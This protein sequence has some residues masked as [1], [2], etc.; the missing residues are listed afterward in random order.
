MGNVQWLKRPLFQTGG[1]TILSRRYTRF[2][3][4][5]SVVALGRHFPTQQL[6]LFEHSLRR[7]LLLVGRVAILT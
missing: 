7:F 1:E 3:A 6:D 4:P 5:Y 2:P